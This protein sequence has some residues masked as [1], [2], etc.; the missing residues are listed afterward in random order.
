MRAQ[1][2][3]KQ[4]AWGVGKRFLFCFWLV[5]RVARFFQDQSQSEVKQKQTNP[6]LLPTLNWKFLCAECAYLRY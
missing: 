2:E 5:E 4:T 6:G 1:S 3:N